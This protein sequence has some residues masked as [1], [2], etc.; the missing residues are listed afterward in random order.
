LLAL[1]KELRQFRVLDPACGSGNFL[2]VAYR[3]LRE[4][5]QRL[6]LRLFAQDKRQF[7]KVGLASG[8]SPKNFFGLDVNEN[9]VETAKVTLMLARRLAHRGAEKFWEDHA[10]ELSGQDTHSLEF[11][12]DLP[13]DNLD[14]NIRC[15]DSLFTSGREC[16]AL[17]MGATN[18]MRSW[19]FTGRLRP[20][21]CTCSA[22]PSATTTG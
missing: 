9:A 7:P 6:L 19:R 13:L 2:F 16:G 1:L 21:K 20:A 12:R 14:A 4:L 22:K 18:V 10:D 15:A 11:E 17:G 3:A 8:I 5:E